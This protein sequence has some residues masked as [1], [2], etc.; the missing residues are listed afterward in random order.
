MPG[1]RDRIMSRDYRDVI[2]GGLLTAIGLLA[3]VVAWFNYPVGNFFHLVG[4]L[5]A[6]VGLVIFLPAWFRS[7]PPLPKPDYRP[8]FVVLLGLLVFALSINWFGLIPAII[9]LTLT[10][11]LADNKLGIIGTIVLAIALAAIA[12]FIFRFALG[13]PLE[14]YKWPF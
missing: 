4:I 12:M 13:L 2:A 1:G 6:G 5:L 11:V 10:S 8:F 9:L 14:P 3:A 7:G